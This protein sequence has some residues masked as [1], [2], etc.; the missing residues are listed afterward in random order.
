VLVVPVD[1]TEVG[2][3]AAR[4]A[5]QWPGHTVR[6]VPNDPTAAAGGARPVG[7]RIA[8][9]QLTAALVDAAVGR[10]AP[11]ASR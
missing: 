7:A 4:T 3:R 11:E 6:P 10:D 1:T 2:L 9:I 5:A 8:L